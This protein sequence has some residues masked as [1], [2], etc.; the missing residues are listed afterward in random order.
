[1]LFYE[2]L[3]LTIFPAFYAI[4]LLAKGASARKWTLLLASTFFYL[5]GEPVFVLV[6]FISIALDYALSFYLERTDLAS[7]PAAGARD[8]HRRQ[9]HRA[10]RLQICGLHRKQSKLRADAVG[11][12]SDSIAGPGSSDW[13]FFC[14]V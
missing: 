7:N 3:F 4:C 8:W 1:M 13:R 10:N 5:W 6:L 11:S 14:G 2:P 9:S 12:A